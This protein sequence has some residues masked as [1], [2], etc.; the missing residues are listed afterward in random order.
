MKS[1]SESFA[2]STLLFDNDE[3]DALIGENHFSIVAH[4]QV[5]PPEPAQV[6]DNQGAT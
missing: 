5:V 3:A 6:F 1:L 4:L 2:L